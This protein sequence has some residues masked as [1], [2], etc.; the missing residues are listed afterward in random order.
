VLRAPLGYFDQ[1]DQ[2][3]YGGDAGNGTDDVE[4]SEQALVAL[5]V[6]KRSGL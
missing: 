3:D 5:T 2:G 6:W 4:T 1:K